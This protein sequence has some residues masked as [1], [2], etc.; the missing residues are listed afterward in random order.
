MRRLLS[1]MGLA[2]LLAATGCNGK[3]P[4]MLKTGMSTSSALDYLRREGM[5]AEDVTGAQLG[6][7]FQVSSPNSDDALGFHEEERR[8]TSIFWYKNW[9]ADRGKAKT[10]R[11]REFVIVKAITAEEIRAG[12]KGVE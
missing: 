1:L 9:R 2:I 6:R 4:A 5:A 3:G 12:L 11:E 8:V 7:T 10:A